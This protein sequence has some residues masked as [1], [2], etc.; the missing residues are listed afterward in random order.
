MAH[1]PHLQNTWVINLEQAQ[2]EKLREKLIHVMRDGFAQDFEEFE[3]ELHCIA[4]PV[5]EH[6]RLVAVIGVSGPAYRFKQQ[7]MH[8]AIMMVKQEL[9]H[10]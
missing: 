3:R 4:V 5:F 1:S 8:E 7:Q 9:L 6:E 2:S 10:Y